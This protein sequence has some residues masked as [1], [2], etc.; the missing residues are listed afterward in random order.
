MSEIVFDNQLPQTNPVHCF[1]AEDGE[2]QFVFLGSYVALWL[3]WLGKVSEPCKGPDCPKSLHKRRAYHRAYLAAIQPELSKQ[4]AGYTATDY[5]L[6]PFSPFSLGG[7]VRKFGVLRGI[8]VKFKI[9][10]K[11][12]RCDVTQ[13]QRCNFPDKLPPDFDVVPHVFRLFGRRPEPLP[14][15]DVPEESARPA[16]VILPEVGIPVREQKEETFSNTR[17]RK[18]LEEH[19]LENNRKNG[20]P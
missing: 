16:Q 3:H 13:A 19:K 11:G 1:K 6:L 5:Q 20:K 15:A 4:K 8:Y 14:L 12:R 18:F 2:Y 10:H 9:T 17:N 7:I